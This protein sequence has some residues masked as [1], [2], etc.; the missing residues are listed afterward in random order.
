MGGGVHSKRGKAE[1]SAATNEGFKKVNNLTLKGRTPGVKAH[2]S[3]H[4]HALG[5]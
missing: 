5:A 3:L 2:G 1:L 4:K